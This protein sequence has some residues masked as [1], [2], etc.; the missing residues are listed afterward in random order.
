MRKGKVAGLAVG[1]TAL[2]VGVIAAAAPAGSAVTKSAAP[3]TPAIV[4]T[5]GVIHPSVSAAPRPPA[6][7]L[8]AS[9]GASQSAP[10]ATVELT[11]LTLRLE[12]DVS[13][14]ETA[15]VRSQGSRASVFSQVSNVSSTSMA[16][17]RSMIVPCTRRAGAPISSKPHLR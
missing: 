15:S 5:P 14:L 17:V 16:P 6:S 4:I 12:A 3:A 1:V 2:A 8:T 10:P 7:R 9:R 13:L 11:I